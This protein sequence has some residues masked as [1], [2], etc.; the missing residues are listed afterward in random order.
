MKEDNEQPHYCEIKSRFDS[1]GI[2]SEIELKDGP[3]AQHLVLCCNAFAAPEA[4]LQKSVEDIRQ[5][6]VS[7]IAFEAESQI[8]VCFAFVGPRN[9]ES[10]GRRLSSKDAATNEGVSDATNGTVTNRYRPRCA[11]LFAVSVAATADH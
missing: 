1:L 9:A 6:E 7:I 3:L 5:R 11:S 4:F 10:I 2:A 8:T